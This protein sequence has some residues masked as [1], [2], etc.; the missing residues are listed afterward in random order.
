MSLPNLT[1]DLFLTNN[2]SILITNAPPEPRHS[3]V[4]VSYF[5][6]CT[7]A[8]FVLMDEGCARAAQTSEA[9]TTRRS[10]KERSDGIEIVRRKAQSRQ[11]VWVQAHGGSRKSS[12]TF[13]PRREPPSASARSKNTNPR[14]SEFVLFFARD[15]VGVYASINIESPKRPKSHCWY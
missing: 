4:W 12:D 2:S 1:M 8:Y 5:A 14:I 11:T 13:E 3:V 6:H 15:C 10:C 9:D 7:E